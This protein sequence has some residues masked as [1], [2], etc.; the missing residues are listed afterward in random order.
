MDF[1]SERMAR[2][3]RQVSHLDIAG[4]GQ[5]Y[6]E[7]STAYVGHMKAAEGTTI[8]DVADPARPAVL[9]NIPTSRLSHAHKVRVVGNLMV[10]NVETAERDIDR[11]YSEGGIRIFDVSRPAEPVELGFFGVT[12][13]GIHRFDFDGTYAYLSSSMDGY[14]H[15]I[16]VIVDLSDPRKPREVS[17]WWM[18]GQWVAGGE[19]P[20]QSRRIGCHHPLRFGDRLYVSYLNGGVVI[21][22]IADIRTPRMVGHYDYHPAFAPITHTF[23]RMPFKLDGRDIAVAVDEQPTRALPGQ[24]PAFMWVFDVTDEKAP[25]PIATWSMSI[26]DTPWRA[27]PNQ[28]LRFGAHQCHERMTDSLVYV[29]WFHGGL[30]IVDLAD[31]SQPMAVGHYIPQPGRG[32]A[33]VMSND[34][35]VDARG[36]IY[37]LDRNRGLDILEYSGPPGMRPG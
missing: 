3:V 13:I 32:Q 12:G 7:G 19:T 10:A 21:L 23:T 27:A 8:I 18:P 34:V 15:N 4:G 37:L 31:P 2:N 14:L 16:V 25:H 33:T 26:D 24:V 28:P 6:V 35:F 30:Q 20:K 11:P 5:I 9:A 22:D 17:R 1:S 36:L 29:A